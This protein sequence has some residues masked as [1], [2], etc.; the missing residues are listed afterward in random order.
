ME[1]YSMINFFGKK[2][3]T[4]GSV[5][6]AMLDPNNIPRHVAIIMDGNG[7]W[8]KRKGLPRSYGHRAGADTLKRIVVAADDLG[9]KV[10]TVYAF[11]TENWKRPDEEVSYIMKLM[12]SYLS[13]NLLELKEHNVQL[14]VIGDMKRLHPD[15]PPAKWQKPS[16]T[17][18]SAPKTLAKRRWPSISIRSRKMTSICSS[19]PVRTSGSAI[20]S[21]GRWPTPNSGTPSSAGPISAKIPWSKLFCPSRAGNGASAA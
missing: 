16:G 19:A 13:K 18:R 10:L 3:E 15:L 1:T 2:K 12:K 8:A 11:S 17:A 9:I 6:E 21:S 5:S 20:S 14:H 4:A 7:R